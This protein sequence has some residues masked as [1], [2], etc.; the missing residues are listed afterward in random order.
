[1]PLLCCKGFWGTLSSGTPTPF[2]QGA[3]RASRL[4]WTVQTNTTCTHNT[5]NNALSLDVAGDNIKAGLFHHP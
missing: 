1:M 3:S 4:H 2:A 5:L